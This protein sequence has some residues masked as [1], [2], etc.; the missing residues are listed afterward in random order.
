MNTFKIKLENCFGI[1]KLDC[2]F[3]FC[4]DG[5]SVG[6]GNAVVYAANGVMK[7][8]FAKTLKLYSEG[9]FD[10]IRDEIYRD[11]KSSISITDE[12]GKN[13]SPE[14]IWVCNVDDYR[15]ASDAIS[16]FLASK[17]LKEEYDALMKVLESK[18]KSL[19][20]ALKEIS[21][22]SDCESEFV[23]T[24]RENDQDTFYLELERLANV[25]ADVDD[26]PYLF[27][28]NVIFDKA[29][30]V[31]E[32]IDKH[33][34]KI[35]EYCNIYGHLLN[36][37]DF[38]HYDK[39]GSFGT[40]QANSLQKTVKD[41]SFFNA[42]HIIELKNG[43][44][45]S[46]AVDLKSEINNCVSLIVNN[47]RARQVFEEIGE[48]LDKNI[49]LRNFKELLISDQSL[50]PELARY[51]LFKKEVWIAYLRDP[52]VN[53]LAI[54]LIESFKREKSKLKA[55]LD[56]AIEETEKWNEMLN[57]FKARFHVPFD[58]VI[59][60][61]RDVVLGM[62]APTL[63]FEYTSGNE[64]RTSV[65]EDLLLG[66][67]SKGERRAFNILQLLFEIEAR[68]LDGLNTLLVLDDISD[69][70]DYRNKYAIVEYLAEIVDCEQ[71]KSIILTHNFDFYRT[72]ISRLGVC[73]EN[74]LIAHKD[75]HGRIR[76]EKGM[77]RRDFFK[78]IVN[79]AKTDI[80]YSLCLIPFARNIAQYANKDNVVNFLT[81]CLHYKKETANI[82]IGEIYKHVSSVLNF[83]VSLNN[84][85]N[86][87]CYL[88]V[89]YEVT[90]KIADECLMAEKV[91]VENK[92]LLAIAIR[93]RAEQYMSK[94]LDKVEGC[95]EFD[96]NQTSNM[97]YE[98]LGKCNPDMEE[99]LLLRR[100]QIMTPEVIH[101]NSFMYEPLIDMSSMEIS[102]LYN[103]VFN[104]L[105]I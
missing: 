86:D 98:F 11:R 100:V 52:K 13:I 84:L 12:N 33:K 3:S 40:Y 15:V 99:V 61:S 79:R 94:C 85:S 54:D 78:Y 64:K 16:K 10:L 89:L 56:E 88:D 103:D 70:F 76:V 75:E 24:F 2:T 53:Y 82:S 28:Y 35:N 46:S 9:K 25:I 74:S 36:Q 63:D 51:E 48:A 87:K 59:K 44:K 96:S 105:K 1:S 23:S 47:S 93:I 91:N 26:C 95:I 92:L 14:E 22:S 21:N 8:S 69:S 39:N 97:L 57:L 42:K 38:F 19:I 55:I 90:R 101:L 73:F 30:V 31:K 45:I 27:K 18:K 71:F 66:V 4:C 37:S 58:I 67:L 65:E 83:D 77:Y 80:S 34:D 7:T 50:V 41:N 17:E 29:G 20:K 43:K 60:N 5:K 102:R 68:R 49:N 104:I 81:K 32:F 6:G 72:I 62:S